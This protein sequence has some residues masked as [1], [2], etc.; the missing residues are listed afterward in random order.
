MDL[1]GK[2]PPAPD[3]ELVWKRKRKTDLARSIWQFLENG[4]SPNIEWTDELA[5]LNREVE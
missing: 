3:S 2:L 5:M 4:Y 1:K